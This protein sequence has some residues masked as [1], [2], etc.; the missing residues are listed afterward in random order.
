MR[1][2]ELYI[3]DRWDIGALA[4]AEKQ[5]VFQ[6]FGQ[7]L[8]ALLQGD[9]SRPNALNTRNAAV[10]RLGILNDFVVGLLHRGV[11]VAKDHRAKF[12]LAGLASREERHGGIRIRGGHRGPRDRR[13][14]MVA[15]G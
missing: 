1:D 12:T 11:D 6:R 5:P 10:E 15:V 3:A 2:L 4:N 14:G 9:P 8:S 7:L 13:D